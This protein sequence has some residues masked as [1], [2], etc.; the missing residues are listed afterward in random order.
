MLGFNRFI[1]TLKYCQQLE[2]W[3][4]EFFNCVRISSRSLIYR[5][6]V[7]DW[8]DQRMCIDSHWNLPFNSGT[9]L[10]RKAIDAESLRGDLNRNFISISSFDWNWGGNA[11]HWYFLKFTTS[12]YLA[13]LLKVMKV[14]SLFYMTCIE[15]FGR[16]VV[17][18]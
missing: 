3:G 8:S 2:G 18:I 9:I 15:N 12:Y 5:P 11:L 14:K 13:S 7:V 17:I 1:K 4:E 10:S 16:S 6:C